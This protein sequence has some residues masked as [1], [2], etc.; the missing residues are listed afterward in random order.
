VQFMCWHADVIRRKAEEPATL[1]CPSLLQNN[2]FIAP[3]SI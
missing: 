1:G 2:L 3:E